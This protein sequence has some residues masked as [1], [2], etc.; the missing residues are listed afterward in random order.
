M[1]HLQPASGGQSGK[2]N[3]HFWSALRINHEAAQ[4]RI[5]LLRFSSTSSSAVFQ[6][7][8]KRHIF[9]LLPSKL[10][11]HS[12]A[13]WTEMI[14]GLLLLWRWVVKARC[15]SPLWRHTVLPSTVINERYN[16]GLC[17]DWNALV[18]VWIKHGLDFSCLHLAVTWKKHYFTIWS[19]Q[20]RCSCSLNK[21]LTPLCL[22]WT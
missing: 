21:A 5:N 15:E 11:K 12:G 20:T 22:K 2:S 4:M 17:A 14:N 16:L 10:M 18:G 6:L 7:C 1:W 19:C 13:G 3:L 8:S 9:P